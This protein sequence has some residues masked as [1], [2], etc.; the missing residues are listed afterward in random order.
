MMDLFL[1]SRVYE[2]VHRRQ[3]KNAKEL[4]VEEG[5]ILEVIA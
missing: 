4:T 5:D 3:G 1:L 2:V